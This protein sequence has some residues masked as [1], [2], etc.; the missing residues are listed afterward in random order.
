MKK[1]LL[2]CITVLALMLSMISVPSQILAYGPSTMFVPSSNVPNPGSLYARAMQAS[3]GKMY[4]T[5]EQ[6][7]SGVSVFP[8]YKSTDNGQSWTKTGEVK[9]THKGVGMRWEPHLYELPQKI[10]D[11]PAGTLLCAGDVVPTNRSSS[12]LDLYKSNDEGKTWTYVS[13]ICMGKDANPG[14]D[15]VWE[16]CIMV[17]NN[18]LICYYSDERDPKHSQKLAHQTT[19]D[20]VHW[21]AVVDDVALSDSGLRPGM[22]VVTKMQN[23]NYLMTYEIVG[24]NGG[25]FYQISS[26]PESWNVRSTGTKFGNSGCPYCTTLGNTVIMSCAATNNLFINSNN[27]IGNWTQISAPL[28]T[29]YS[30]CLV[31]L[32]NGRLF[33]IGAGWNG[34]S[35]N[36][37]TYADMSV[38]G[39]VV[40]TK[41]V[42]P[43][44]PAQSQTPVVNALKDGWYYI[45]GVESGKYLQVADNTGK[46]GQN[47]ETGSKSEK[48][49][50]KWYLTNNGD[51]TVT[52]K[53]GLG[54]FMLDVTAGTNQDGTNIEIYDA[55]SHTPQQFIVKASG[56]NGS[57][58][59]YTAASNQTKVIDVA[60][61]NLE[62]GANVC[63]WTYGGGANQQWI[64]EAVSAQDTSS[65]K[66]A[67]SVQPSQKPSDEPSSEPSTEPSAAVSQSPVSESI[68]AIEAA[69]SSWDS[70]YNMNFTLC[71]TS[72]QNV[73]DWK[74]TFQNADTVINSIWCAKKTVS[75]TKVTITPES[76][77]AQLAAGTSTTFGF[78]GEGKMP[79]VLNYEI[80][81]LV[82]GTWQ[83]A[84]GS[85]SAK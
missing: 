19:T 24:T 29:C 55:R 2:S 71:N 47:V 72:K 6:Y 27:G 8:I 30:R 42:T 78:G 74:I 51:G 36:N 44:S 84:T 34:N 35:K 67:V 28:G 62:D 26:D 9:D 31:P 14:G 54:D 76:Y 15:P 50:Q 7:S 41:P 21:S 23:G 52:L 85:C 83:S 43:T 68:L 12:E 58:F 17:A 48:A 57:C 65:T 38:P 59:I 40:D 69:G 64:F 13:T 80:S 20:G 4:A 73:E 5:F 56:N 66:P 10:G 60:N 61:H 53:S 33:L 39:A 3:N 16:P 70:G 82:N 79:S 22:P 81:Y 37:V 75:G 45:K 25:A 77:N 32:S 11:I 1:K 46:A 49:G 18:K 63:Q